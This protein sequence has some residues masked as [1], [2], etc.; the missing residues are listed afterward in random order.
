MGRM[1]ELKKRY[2]N[3][4]LALDSLFISINNYKTVLKLQDHSELYEKTFQ[5]DYENYYRTVRDSLIQRFEYCVDSVWKY[6]KFYLE[7]IE[8]ITLETKSPR[9]IIREACQ[10][11]ILNEK[12]TQLL[13]KMI[14]YRN[15]TSHIYKEETADIISK[16][17]PNFYLLMRKI[18]D[19]LRIN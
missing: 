19:S 2:K 16:E 14:D 13:L 12:D 1:D 11:R 8:K 15:K 4:Q 10:A 18:F 3:F 9:G 7:N 6:L 5:G 17:V